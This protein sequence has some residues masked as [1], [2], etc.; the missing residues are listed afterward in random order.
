MLAS[1]FAERKEMNAH[2]PAAAVPNATACRKIISITVARL[3]EAQQLAWI[4]KVPN[5]EQLCAHVCL[6]G[7]SCNSTLALPSLSS[8]KRMRIHSC[9]E[10]PGGHENG[11]EGVC[12]YRFLLDNYDAP[13]DGVFF[14]HG[15][16]PASG[17]HVGQFNSFQ[18]YLARNE[19]PAWPK[20]RAKMSDRYC[21]C[22]H[23]ASQFNPFG[24]RDF[25]FM[26][27][28]WWMG[29]MIAPRDD[30]ARASAEDWA[31]SINCFKSRPESWGK[32]VCSRAGHGAWPLHQGMM[33]SPIGFMFAVDR[34]SALQRSR[35]FLE[36]Q[37]RICK[38][39]VRI[40]PP[41]LTS[42]PPVVRLSMPGF[43]YN[44]LVYGHVNERIPFFVFGHEFVE[45][46]PMPA[47][48]WE[49]DHGSMNCSQ[50]LV[51]PAPHRNQRQGPGNITSAFR[52]GCKPFADGCGTTVG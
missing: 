44:P 30:E 15:D 39:G 31:A 35:R 41:Y 38:V 27:L 43:D 29:A 37:Y 51:P 34:A 47:C 26:G 42:A 18:Q 40:M 21:G 22:G 23:W 25:W 24:P 2:L 20:S 46:E 19:W 10:E 32:T 45:R 49:G 3:H 1:V 11:H 16:A 7:L 12:A 9:V 8:L 50:P 13:W 36:A 17:K 4:D 28:T 6:K 52:V 14:L 33:N 5:A 48:L